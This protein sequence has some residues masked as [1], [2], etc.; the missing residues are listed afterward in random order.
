MSKIYTVTELRDTLSPI[1]AKHG[2]CSA[3]LFGSYAKGQSTERSDVDLLVDSGLRGLA[4]FGLLEDVVS[5]L[6]VPVDMIDVSQ[7]DHGSPV[8]LEIGQ[9]GVEIYIGS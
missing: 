4:F 5:A 2:V 7:V 9:C 8:E 3:V 6:D 1:F